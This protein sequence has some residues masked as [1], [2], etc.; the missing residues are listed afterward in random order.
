LIVLLALTLCLGGCDVGSS[1]AREQV[2]VTGSTTLLPIAEVAGE[3][4]GERHEGVSILVSGLGSSA[5]IESVAKGSSD[6]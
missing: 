5:G 2:V 6:I 1:G 4:Y 3:M